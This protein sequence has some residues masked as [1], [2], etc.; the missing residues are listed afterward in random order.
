MSIASSLLNPKCGIRPSGR[1]LSGASKN[2][3]NDSTLY[4]A[5]TSGKGT[6]RLVKSPTFG[7][8]AA[9]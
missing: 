7:A 1:T 9:G 5:F 8:P 4:F 2:A 6:G 3:A